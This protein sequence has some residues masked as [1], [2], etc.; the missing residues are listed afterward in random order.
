AAGEIAVPVYLAEEERGRRRPLRIEQEVPEAAFQPAGL[1]LPQRAEPAQPVARF[2]QRIVQPL[3]LR[4]Q[5][6][7]AVA[8]RTRHAAILAVARPQGKRAVGAR[9]ATRAGRSELPA[10]AGDA[11]LRR[12]SRHGRET[13]GWGPPGCCLHRRFRYPFQPVSKFW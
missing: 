1:P 7:E 13:A 9:A 12:P 8:M 10:A 2:A 5:V 3:V 6:V 4:E 11:H